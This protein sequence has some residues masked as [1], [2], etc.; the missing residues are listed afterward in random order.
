MPLAERIENQLGDSSK[1]FEELSEV[2]R[3]NVEKAKVFA[4]TGRGYGVMQGTRPSTIS[5][6]VQSSPV[7]LL[8]WCRF[9]I[10]VSMCGR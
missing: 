9:P 5:F 7:A 2:E 10:I 8:A 6:L 4:S 1:S 3:E